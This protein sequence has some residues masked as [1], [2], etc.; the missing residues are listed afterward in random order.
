MNRKT[1]DCA[2]VPNEVGC[3][4]ALTGSEQELLEVAV[5]HAVAVHGHTDS[6]ELR[7]ALRSAMTEEIDGLA[8][9]GSFVQVLEFT[10]DQVG[11]WS[12]IQDRLIDTLG[13]DRTTRW[14]MLGADRD[15][16]GRY[17]AL[18]HFPD[19]AAAMANSDQPATGVWFKEL[20]AICTE[21]PTF[22]NLDVAVVRP[23]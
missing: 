10:T 18:V 21:E 12:E 3:T 22:R 11:R 6:A 16:P 4:L 14:S 7:S 8:D 2:S 19:H 9:A 1:I 17:L 15:R 5:A 20:Q 23:Y 13:G